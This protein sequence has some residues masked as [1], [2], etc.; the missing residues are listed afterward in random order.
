MT[1]LQWDDTALRRVLILGAGED[2]KWIYRR[3]REQHPDLPILGMA[4]EKHWLDGR[5]G[6]V[7]FVHPGDIRDVVR[8]IQRVGAS[9]IAFFGKVVASLGYQDISGMTM[10]ILKYAAANFTSLSNP[11]VALPNVYFLAIRD[12]IHNRGFGLFSLSDVMPNLSK[13][14]GESIGKGSAMLHVDTLSRVLAERRKK[15]LLWRKHGA[16]VLKSGEVVFQ[17]QGTGQL[18]KDA[19]R[20]GKD[21]RDATLIKTEVEEFRSI[22]VPVLDKDLIELCKLHGI[23][24]IV[25]SEGSIFIDEHSVSLTGILDDFRVDFV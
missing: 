6:V 18:I 24:H 25:A 23:N 21:L 8:Q 15:P 1:A 17:T 10:T 19:S 12:I 13:K 9:E 14:R 2:A 5:D 20:R 4:G 11:T 16:L 7:G 22:D 3:T